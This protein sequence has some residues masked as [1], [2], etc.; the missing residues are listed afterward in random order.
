MPSSPIGVLMRSMSSVR[1]LSMGGLVC[2][3]R[4]LRGIGAPWPPGFGAILQVGGARPR[5]N[6]DGGTPQQT[7]I[8]GREGIGLAH[9]PQ[10]DVVRRPF[11]DAANRAQP[12]D[13][14]LDGAL[15]LEQGR[16][17]Q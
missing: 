10:R 9:R 3:P 13:R 2:G 14:F 1:G 16:I 7:D 11:A 15:R 6:P 12:R 8:A 17:L 5:A 4:M